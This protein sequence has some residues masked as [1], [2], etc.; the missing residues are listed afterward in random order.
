MG[1]LYRNADKK[2]VKREQKQ[3]PEEEKLIKILEVDQFSSGAEIEKYNFE[4]FDPAN[5]ESNGAK[6]AQKIFGGR[7]IVREVK[8]K[9]RPMMGRVW[10]TEVK[11]YFKLYR[12]NY[13]SSD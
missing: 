7:Y 10:Y 12:A 1:E 3:K 13:D 9:D 2:E 4:T 11:N 5:L 6:A 8:P